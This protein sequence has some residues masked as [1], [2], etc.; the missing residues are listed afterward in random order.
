MERVANLYRSEMVEK[1]MKSYLASHDHDAIVF[2]RHDND[3]VMRVTDVEVKSDMAI[4]KFR[5]TPRGSGEYLRD[6]VCEPT[7]DELL[8][9][10]DWKCEDRLLASSACR[11]LDFDAVPDSCHVDA[12]PDVPGINSSCD[13]ENDGICTEIVAKKS[14][15]FQG[16]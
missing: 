13:C 3:W 9:N 12:T 7:C 14:V 4:L 11:R 6:M 5:G 1:Y 8:G 16:L 15:T 10:I 2:L